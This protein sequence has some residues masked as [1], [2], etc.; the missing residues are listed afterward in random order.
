MSIKHNIF[1][2]P[3]WGFY[4]KHESW[5]A[6][7]QEYAIHLATNTKSVSKSNFKG[8]QSHDYM[9]REKLFQPFVHQ[10][11]TVANSEILPE[12]PGSPFEI[13]ALWINV[14]YP[15]AFNMS[16][17]H[18]HAL[19][20]VYYIT[21]PSPATQSG[22]LVFIDPRQRVSMSTQ[23]IKSVNFPIVPDIGACIIFPSWLEHYVEPNQSAETRI[24]ISFN[25]K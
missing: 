10:L 16:H 4:W 15:G 7:V 9:H 18:E 24:S 13:D 17:I 20:G 3:I 14:N 2:S 12:Y 23:R 6:E 21:V 5:I 1:S 22:K 25:L 11:L 19:S 8:W